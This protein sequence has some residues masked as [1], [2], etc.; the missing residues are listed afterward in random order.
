MRYLRSKDQHADILTKPIGR[1]SL[2]K[3]RNILLGKGE[4]SNYIVGPNS[5][6]S[7]FAVSPRV[8]AEA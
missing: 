4:T 6:R 2:E 7:I 1:E 3:H 8:N 5:V